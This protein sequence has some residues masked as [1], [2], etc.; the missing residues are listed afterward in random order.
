[1]IMALWYLF[2]SITR[3]IG[4]TNVILGYILLVAIGKKLKEKEVYLIIRI[5]LRFEILAILNI[6]IITKLNDIIH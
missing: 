3:K 4:S 6:R 1:M 5:N 2:D